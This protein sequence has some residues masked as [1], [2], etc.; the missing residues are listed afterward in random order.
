MCLANQYI[1]VYTILGDSMRSHS[2]HGPG[3]PRLGPH[4]RNDV[5]TE[6]STCSLLV[7]VL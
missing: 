6:N 3:T 7:N 2:P 4:I 5:V 1:H